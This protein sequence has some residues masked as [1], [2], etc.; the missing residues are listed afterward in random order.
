MSSRNPISLRFS[1]L[2]SV[3]LSRFYG[4]RF[5]ITPRAMKEYLPRLMVLLLG[6]LLQKLLSTK[7]LIGQWKKR[8]P[9]SSMRSLHAIQF[10]H[11]YKTPLA[12]NPW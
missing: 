3:M 7:F 8:I 4:L 6:A 1:R 11:T 2:S 9:A 10:K 5:F 12:A